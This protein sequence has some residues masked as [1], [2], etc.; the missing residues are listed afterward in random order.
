MKSVVSLI[1]IES[2][3]FEIIRKWCIHNLCKL[4]ID[5]VTLVRE[6]ICNYLNWR[7]LKLNVVM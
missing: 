6:Q 3:S 1:Y 2:I 5:N 4:T 7:V